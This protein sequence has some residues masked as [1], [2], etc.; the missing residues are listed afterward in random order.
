MVVALQL[1]SPF[2]DATGFFKVRHLKKMLEGGGSAQ[3][4]G[5]FLGRVCGWS[6]RQ[7]SENL[8]NAVSP[9]VLEMNNT[10]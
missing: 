6:E 9:P 2:F 4:D 3:G 5:E 8:R 1:F 7:L 10:L